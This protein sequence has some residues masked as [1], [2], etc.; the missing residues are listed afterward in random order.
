MKGIFRTLFILAVCYFIPLSQGPFADTSEVTEL[1][2]RF[3]AC[4]N[5]SSDE[6]I[7]LV[8]KSQDQGL[9]K[10]LNHPLIARRL[11]SRSYKPAAGPTKHAVKIRNPYSEQLAEYIVLRYP[12]H[13]AMKKAKEALQH[14]PEVLWVGENSRV[15]FSAVPS[16]PLFQPVGSNNGYQWGLHAL[17]MDQVWDLSRG[18]AYIAMIDVSIDT[19]HPDLQNNFRSQFSFDF[20]FDNDSVDTFDPEDPQ[21]IVVDH[22][23]HATNVAGILAAS[24][25][26]GAGVSGVCWNCS[27]MVGK[28]STKEVSTDFGRIDALGRQEHIDNIIDGINY[29]ISTGA[30][31]IN[32]SLH[33]P[34]PEVACDNTALSPD[35]FCLA[36]ALADYRDVPIAAAAGNEGWKVGDDN[37]NVDFP[38][39]DPRVIAVGAVNTDGT[40]PDWSNKGPEID[41]VAPGESILSTFNKDMDW[42]LSYPAKYSIPFA[43]NCGDSV[44]GPSGYGPCSGTSMATPHVA[45]ILGILRSIN[46]LLKRE[47]LKELLTSNASRANSPDYAYGHGMPKPLASVKGALGMVDGVTLK[48]RLTPLFSLYSDSGEDYF[49]TT[50]PQMAMAAIYDQLQPQ[51]P[52]SQVNWLPS[53]GSSVPGYYSFP[54]YFWML[55]Y[56]PKASVYIFTTYNN[57]I[58][59]TSELVPLYRLSYQGNY[60][61][62]NA[63]NVDHTYTTEQRG[64]EIFESLGY[65]LDGIEGYIYPRTMDQPAG[66]VKLYRKYNPA[67]DDYAIFPESQLPGMIAQGYTENFGNEWIGF[68]YPNKDSDRDGVIDGF[69]IVIGTDSTNR[70]SDDDGVLDGT[71][72]NSYPYSD[73]LR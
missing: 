19:A 1:I 57:P 16:D 48:N 41:L 33:A 2:V 37:W 35:P 54:G 15:A 29:M 45:G 51:P 63:L 55:P 36:L 59:S 65:K 64:V 5:K 61:G 28:V 69:E 11:L 73:P 34:E 42:I 25:D 32:L 7:Q 62:T 24:S 70:D 9:V 68:V 58:D 40:V 26:N 20:G 49:Y 30:Q 46:P 23:G 38:A 18:H 60:T 3:E 12:S 56:R 8:N 72:I 13:Q 50:V 17:N 6:I 47:Q 71:E 27:L 21:N 66:T 67:R 31:V 4:T 43:P 53:G 10:R 52:G 39:S 22:T 14:D 44:S